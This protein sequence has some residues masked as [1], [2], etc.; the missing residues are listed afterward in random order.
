MFL[1][2]AQVIDSDQLIGKIYSELRKVIKSYS[3]NDDVLEI[4]EFE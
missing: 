1:E 4:A 2:L 3:L